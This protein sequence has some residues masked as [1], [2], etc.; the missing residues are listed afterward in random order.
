MVETT[1]GGATG[2]LMNLSYNQQASA[3]QLGV[4]TTAGNAG[5]LIGVSGA[6]NSQAR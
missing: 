5:Q 4:G 1:Q 2:N 3:G 6:I